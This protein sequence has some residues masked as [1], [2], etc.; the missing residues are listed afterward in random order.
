V[1]GFAAEQEQRRAGVPNAVELDAPQ[2]GRLGQPWVRPTR[3]P[4][5]A[6]DQAIVEVA[7]Y[8]SVGRQRS[9]GLTATAL[10][11]SR[12]VCHPSMVF[13]VLTRVVVRGVVGWGRRRVLQL[14]HSR[15]RGSRDHL[16]DDR[17]RG[18]GIYQRQP[19]LGSRDTQTPLA[20]PDSPATIHAWFSPQAV[21]GG[22]NPAASTVRARFRSARRLAFSPHHRQAVVDNMAPASP[23]RVGRRRQRRRPFR[24]QH[25]PERTR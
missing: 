1:H 8:L 2:L 17:R 15:H 11:S 6:V 4:M 3:E 5:R 20:N 10:Q 7:A 25:H 16:D 24:S 21:P 22:A 18:L 19:T 23:F 13:L 14:P 12:R 9:A